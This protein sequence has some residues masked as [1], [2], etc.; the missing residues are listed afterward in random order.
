[1]LRLIMILRVYRPTFERALVK[2]IEQ[3]C[4]GKKIHKIHE[5][6]KVSFHTKISQ[7]LVG[8]ILIFIIS[9]SEI[10]LFYPLKVTNSLHFPAFTHF[11]LLE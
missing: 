8:E 11:Y 4:K 2:N 6:A 7:H 1:M 3:S 9:P 5:C 10:L